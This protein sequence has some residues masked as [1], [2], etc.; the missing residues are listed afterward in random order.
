MLEHLLGLRFA[1]ACVL[2]LEMCIRDRI[3]ADGY[4]GVETINAVDKTFTVRV[5]AES[6]ILGTVVLVL[7]LIGLVGGIAVASIKIARR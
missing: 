4:S 6:N 2:C 1:I 5:A 7:I 3:S